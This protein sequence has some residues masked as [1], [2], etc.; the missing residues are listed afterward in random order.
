MFSTSG[1]ADVPLHVMIAVPM[2]VLLGYTVFGAT[3]FGSSIISVPGLA[4]FFPLTFTVPLITTTDAFAATATAL[5]LRRF[6]AWREIARLLPA[7][8]IGLAL[9]ATL[10]LKLPRAP[11]LLALGTFAASYGAYVLTGARKL[12]RA[13]AWL[14]WPV[15][16]V[17]GIFSALFGTGGPVYIVF[18]SARLPDK[19]QLRATSAVVIAISV[20]IRVGLFIA[21][22]LLLERG[23]VTLVV[24][25]LPV[26]VL[27]LWLG[28]RLHHALS[29]RGVLRLIAALLLGNGV[30]LIARAAAMMR[31]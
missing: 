28:N 29:G 8:L 12:D 2:I 6:V 18:L 26:M 13:P 10:L 19:E 3:G 11:A 20:Y 27:G 21:T 4:H 17:G 16:V 5:R 24:A 30:A 9:G 22:G 14:V 7:M 1:L 25:L 31:E 15:G 23:L